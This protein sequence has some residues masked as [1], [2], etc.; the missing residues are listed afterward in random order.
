M[1]VPTGYVGVG[2]SALWCGATR[3]N[4]ADVAG[5]MERYGELEKSTPVFPW[6]G[7]PYQIC[8]TRKEQNM[9]AANPRFARG[10]S[11]T[12]TSLTCSYPCVG[13]KFLTLQNNKP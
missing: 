1:G 3:Q 13:F 10:E 6:L 9:F 7:F 12:L 8:L 5:D 11:Y 4:T 2:H